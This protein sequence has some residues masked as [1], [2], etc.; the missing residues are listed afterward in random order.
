MEMGMGRRSVEEMWWWSEP[1]W[2]RR[3]KEVVQ[4]TLLVS[5]S[6]VVFKAWRGRTVG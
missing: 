3:G 4:Q 5:G 6:E 1:G 2:G